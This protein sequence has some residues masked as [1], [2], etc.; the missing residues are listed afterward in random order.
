MIG[1]FSVVSQARSHPVGDAVGQD[2][3]VLVR[4]VVPLA[5]ADVSAGTVEV[6]VR[7]PGGLLPLVAGHAGEVGIGQPGA[8]IALRMGG[9]VGQRHDRLGRRPRS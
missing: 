7:H 2:L 9:V 6:D 3:A 1:V 5:G 8:V 4:T